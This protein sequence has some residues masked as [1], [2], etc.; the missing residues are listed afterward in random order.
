MFTI[1]LYT[2]EKEAGIVSVY[3]QVFSEYPWL[4]DWSYTDV[5]KSLNEPG[6]RWWIATD[7]DR[8]VG[9]T[10]WL[11]TDSATLAARLKVPLD[12]L[13]AGKIAYLAE[14]GMLESYRGQGLAKQLASTGEA[15]AKEMGGTETVLRT[16]PDAITY[17]WYTSKGYHVIYQYED[18]RVVLGK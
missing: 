13:P 17:P 16:K 7:G 2:N 18:G 8:V 11:V 5:Q 15:W 4:E 6:L 3:K 1:S 10:A 9:F 14:V 12:C